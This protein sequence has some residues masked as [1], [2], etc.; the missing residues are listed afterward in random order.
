MV[1]LILKNHFQRKLQNEIMNQVEPYHFRCLLIK[2]F[3]Q[4]CDL[5]TIKLCFTE[6]NWSNKLTDDFQL[7]LGKQMFVITDVEGYFLSQKSV[8]VNKTIRMAEIIQIDL[9]D[10][11]L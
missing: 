3:K 9:V 5:L 10:S 4:Y 8:N 1:I 11:M 2:I 6:N 7:P